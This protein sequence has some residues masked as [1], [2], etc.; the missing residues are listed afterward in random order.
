MRKESFSQAVKATLPVLTG[1]LAAGFAFG[2][3]YSKIGYDMVFTALTSIFVYAGSGQYLAVE[4]L[5]AGASFG[6]IAVLT[7]IVNSRHI[8]YGFSM[9]EKFK[10]MGKRKWY[11][12]FSLTD[13]TYALLGT[14]TIPPGLDAGTFYFQVALLNQI[15][16]VTGGMLGNLIG[17]TVKLN[18]R[19]A[20]FAMTAIFVVSLVEQ[21]KKRANRLPVFIGL[22]CAAVSLFFFGGG[23]M[24]F[25]A[26][27]GIILLLFLF[28]RKIEP[29]EQSESKE[30]E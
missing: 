28:K 25:P 6:S 1:Y 11:M 20:E 19:G 12:I 2:L 3:M 4:L 23:N 16:W 24:L 18:Y 7:F 10:T 9:I 22:V 21:W 26:M 13:E 30:A 15:Y 8:L 29:D 27:C 5:S 17:E 14:L